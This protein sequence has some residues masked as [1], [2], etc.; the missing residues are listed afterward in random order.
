[1]S[2]NIL[3][4]ILIVIVTAFLGW[5]ARRAWSAPNPL[6]KWAGVFF[7]G[8]LMLV[9]GLVAVLATVGMIKY[10]SHTGSP[11]PALKVEGT[12]EQI[13]RGEHLA[14][15]FC[16]DCHSSNAE[17]PMTGGRDLATDLGMPLGKFMSAN[18]TP[19]GPLKDWTDGEI[20]RAL[21]EG[22]DN[23][24]Q[25]L[26]VMPTTN[27]RY[28]SDE[29]MHAVIA[30]L[31]S[32]EPVKGEESVPLDQP[33]LLAFIFTGANMIPVKPP[34]DGI[35]SAPELSP[36]AEYGKFMVSFLD[37]KDCHGE[38][39]SG[40]TSQFAP[41][42]PSLRVVKGWTRDEFIT[43]LRTGVDPAGNVL[44]PPMPWK[45]AGRLDDTELTAL[46]E[47]LVSLE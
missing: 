46:Y 4:V 30:F 1:M 33:N 45:S 37:C 3:L 26:V 18:L 11:A 17:F 43:T 19:A 32:Q 9:S 20:F 14:S 40:G 5:I 41:Q 34:V 42:G 31:R 44:K 27:V 13:A 47:Y 36:A 22:V 35:I 16:V 12:P 25:R 23:T 10:Y 29:D 8:L 2:V 7:A 6:A 15:A 21:R 24:G 28:I 39:L 38:D